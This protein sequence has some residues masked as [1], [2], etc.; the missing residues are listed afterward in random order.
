MCCQLPHLLYLQILCEPRAVDIRQFLFLPLRLPLII[1]CSSL[2]GHNYWFGLKSRCLATM[3][4]HARQF[5]F[6]LVQFRIRGI[7]LQSDWSSIIDVWVR[8]LWCQR[9]QL[10]VSQCIFQYCIL[11]QWKTLEVLWWHHCCLLFWRRELAVM[12]RKFH[13]INVWREE[14]LFGQAIWP[15]LKFM[16]SW[17]VWGLVNCL[18]DLSEKVGLSQIQHLSAYIRHILFLSTALEAAPRHVCLCPA[19]EVLIEA[20]VE[21]SSARRLA[22]VFV[23][24]TLWSHFNQSLI[25]VIIIKI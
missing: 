14:P 13:A 10:F 11:Q 5:R 3:F 21:K 9:C 15:W 17:F 4:P 2:I 16:R 24:E 12:G 25:I 20:L 6:W 18:V 23:I 19:Q 22:N 7:Y 8:K 1:N